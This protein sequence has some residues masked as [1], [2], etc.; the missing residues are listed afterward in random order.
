MSR[1]ALQS[2]K[3]IEK[4][5]HAVNDGRVLGNHNMIVF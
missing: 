1:V 4:A 5:Y 2:D 3:E